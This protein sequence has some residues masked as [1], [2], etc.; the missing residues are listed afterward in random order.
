MKNQKKQS[1]L[2]FEKPHDSNLYNV[3]FGFR[4][5]FTILRKVIGITFKKRKIVKNIAIVFLLLAITLLTSSNGHR[6]SDFTVKTVVIDAGHGGHDPGTHGV[7]SEEKDIALDVALQ[8]GKYIQE[9]L[10][11]VKVIYTRKDDKFV[12][13]EQRAHVAN[14]NHADVFISIH[15]N[16]VSKSSIYGT[17]TYVMGPHKTEG[18]LDVAKRENSVILYEEGY[19]EK[20]E[21]FDPNSPESHILFSLTQSAYIENSLYLASKIEEQFGTRAGRRSR[22]VKQA[23]F[24]VL[25]RTAMPSVLVEIGYLTNPKEEQELNNSS[26]KAN[27]ASGIFR[28]FRDYKNNIESLN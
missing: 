18:N 12:E 11:D 4:E 22:G 21:G 27:I 3:F 8:L 10:P 9:Y 19:E 5:K 26:V 15:A 1:K 13:L 20:Y 23:G 25:W 28:A 16:A 6:R 2:Y 17:E 14:K 7:F 24:W